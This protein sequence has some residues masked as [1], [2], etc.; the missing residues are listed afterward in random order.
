MSDEIKTEVQP[1]TPQ[2][3][4]QP[5]VPEVV[6]DPVPEVVE[7]PVEAP[8]SPNVKVVEIGGKKYNQI[9]NPATGVTTQELLVD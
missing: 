1:E 4:V 6:A 3:E 2:E 7:P 9:F 5:E 8:V